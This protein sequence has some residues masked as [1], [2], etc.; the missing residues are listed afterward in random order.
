[1]TIVLKG[2]I[3][4]TG[5]PLSVCQAD[6]L[7]DGQYIS[8]VAKDISIEG[9]GVELIDC[10]R[11]LVTPGLVNGHIHLNQVLNRGALDELSTEALLSS[12]H[13]RHEAKSDVDRYWG[14]LL[15]ISE[16]LSSGTTYFSAFA[17]GSGL[18]G[19]AMHDAGVRGTLT[20][21]KKDQWWGDGL[22]PH[23][24]LLHA[25]FPPGR[26]ESLEESREGTRDG[27]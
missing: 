14:S 2:G 3:V 10:S 4:A 21:A 25:L 24:T 26:R 6:V 20:V 17:T 5:Y 19:Q 23:L 7:I 27:S 12:M 18:I 16:A 13:S 9:P 15:S 1:M 11:M 8:Q 22:Q